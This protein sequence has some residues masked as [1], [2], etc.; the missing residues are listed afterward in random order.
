MAQPFEGIKVVELSQGMAGSLAGCLLADYGADV[1]KVEPP[2]GERTRSYPG[3]L[4]WNRGKRSVV[5][6]LAEPTDRARAVELAS[7]ADVLIENFRPGEAA[8]VGLDG[9]RL[10]AANPGLI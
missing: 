4:M 3:F 2:G 1:V 9:D 10:R 5:L 8:R 7:N 6:D